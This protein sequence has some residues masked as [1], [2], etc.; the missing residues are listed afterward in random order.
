MRPSSCCRRSVA[1]TGSAPAIDVL[2][3]PRALGEAWLSTY[4]TQAVTTPP[5]GPPLLDEAVTTGAIWRRSLSV[6]PGQYYLVLD[7][8]P[9]AGR[10]APAGSAR[11]DQA[12]QVSFGVE[13]E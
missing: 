8:T 11:D 10:T 12:A 5:P 13:L 6:P 2:L 7:N 1:R 3:M 9:T 4:V